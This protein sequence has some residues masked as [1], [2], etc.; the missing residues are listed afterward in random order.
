MSAKVSL[1]C[2][3]IVVIFVSGFL[4][5]LSTGTTFI[6]KAM[7]TIDILV[8]S[9]ATSGMWFVSDDRRRY[10]CA[11]AVTGWTLIL[12]WR[13][14]LGENLTISEGIA[15]GILPYWQ[16]YCTSA[17]ENLR[18]SQRS[19]TWFL[20]T[21]CQSFLILP[22]ASLGGACVKRWFSSDITAT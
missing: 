13:S 1:R 15:E 14:S 8:L 18:Q 12:F 10:W 21:L 5:A 6:I 20:S 16:K 3:F 9:I 7:W 4:G 22:I 11:F 17:V 2:F 19:P